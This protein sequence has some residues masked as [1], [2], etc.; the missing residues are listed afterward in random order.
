M[1]VTSMVCR[2]GALPGA[3]EAGAYVP[4]AG[5]SDHTAYRAAIA[6]LSNHLYPRV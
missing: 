4:I 2:V 6:L 1:G 5:V 3:V